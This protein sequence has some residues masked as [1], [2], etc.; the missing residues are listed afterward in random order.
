MV[1]RKAINDLLAR[2]T[3]MKICKLNWDL[4]KS[5]TKQ[6]PTKRKFCKRLMQTQVY[7]DGLQH[8]R[9]TING[10]KVFVNCKP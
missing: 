6:I 8:K 10:I 5:F 3:K 7:K 1:C 9:L 2:I 4:H